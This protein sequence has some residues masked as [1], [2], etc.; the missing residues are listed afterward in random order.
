[1]RIIKISDSLYRIYNKRG[2]C[3][4]VSI[5]FGK[6]KEPADQH[7]ILTETEKQAVELKIKKNGIDKSRNIS[8]R[9]N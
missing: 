8:E 1:M 3:K 2:I 9:N 4:D 5:E 6:I 7:D